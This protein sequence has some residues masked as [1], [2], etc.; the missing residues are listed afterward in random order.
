MTYRN[1]AYLNTAKDEP[2]IKCGRNDGTVVA[3]HYSGLGAYALGKGMGTKVFD[4]ATAH[5]CSRCHAEFDNYQDDN[6]IERSQEFLMLILRTLKKNVE[7]G[8]KV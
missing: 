6:T 8:I 7:R 4:L 2:C 5:L 1:R 3:A